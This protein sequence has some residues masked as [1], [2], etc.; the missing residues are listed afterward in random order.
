MLVFTFPYQLRFA[1]MK[2]QELMTNA[3]H[4]GAILALAF[5]VIFL[6]YVIIQRD[7]KKK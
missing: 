2:I 4:T 6:T 3:N 1:Y 7:S 5:A